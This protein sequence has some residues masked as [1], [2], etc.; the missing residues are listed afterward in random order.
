MYDNLIRAYKCMV[1]DQFGNSPEVS[2]SFANDDIRIDAEIDEIKEHYHRPN[3]FDMVDALLGKLSDEN[4]NF[5]VNA[6]DEEGA[7]I[8]EKAFNLSE[9]S[10]ISEV[11]D[12][13]FM[14]MFL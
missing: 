3:H 1:E 10:L 14:G 7:E 4:L 13:M 6:P 9:A 11:L 2:E 8:F 5:V 12:E